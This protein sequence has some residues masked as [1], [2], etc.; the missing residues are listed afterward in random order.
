MP[1]MEAVAMPTGIHV[2]AR[3]PLAMLAS[4]GP[5]EARQV[6]ACGRLGL[7]SHLAGAAGALHQSRSRMSD[8]SASRIRIDFAHW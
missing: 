2:E 7:V 8:Q 4:I 5:R 1:D 3:D 6:F